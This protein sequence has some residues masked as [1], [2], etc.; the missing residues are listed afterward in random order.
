MSKCTLALLGV[1]LCQSDCYADYDIDLLIGDT[2]NTPPLKTSLKL[3]AIP[4]EEKCLPET[5][6]DSDGFITY[7][8][9][10]LNQVISP[11]HYLSLKIQAP[12]VSTSELVNIKEYAS[13]SGQLPTERLT[14][15]KWHHILFEALNDK[16]EW[17]VVPLYWGY[18]DQTIMIFGESKSFSF[19]SYQRNLPKF[20][21]KTKN[22]KDVIEVSLVKK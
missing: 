16:S 17:E 5:I 10:K 18:T 20:D 19:S 4:E 6:V 9:P 1:L 13:F 8:R 7:E 11:G 15:Q 14:N 2:H 21:K 3:K 22:Y 12:K